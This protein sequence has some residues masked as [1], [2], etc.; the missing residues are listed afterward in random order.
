MSVLI[1]LDPK[2]YDKENPAMECIKTKSFVATVALTDVDLISKDL[3]K[4]ITTALETLQPLIIFL[5]RA[6]SE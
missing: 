4:K 3:V 2:G 1:H 6:L 5:N